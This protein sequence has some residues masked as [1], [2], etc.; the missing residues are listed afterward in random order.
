MHAQG[1]QFN[2]KLFF[3]PSARGQS[4][5]NQKKGK[6]GQA[7]LGKIHVTLL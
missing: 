4:E 7:L 6:I 3:P 5:V 2:Q 1:S